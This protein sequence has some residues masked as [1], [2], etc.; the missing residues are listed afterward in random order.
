M[1]WPTGYNTAT[2]NFNSTNKPDEQK[3]GY[4]T[5]FKGE[6]R[7]TSE[8]TASQLAKLNAMFG[9]D[10]RKQP[11]WAAPNLYYVDLELNDDFTGIRWNG[12]EKTYDLDK[13]VNVVLT[14]MRKQ[15]PDFGLTGMLVA[16]GEELEDRWML[17][18]GDDG[19]AH[20]DKLAVSGHV[21]TCPHCS[22]RFVLEEQVQDGPGE[23]ARAV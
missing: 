4:S 21:V 16:Q 10:C 6:L 3:M 19:W 12:A 9:A 5:E 14:Q 8:A 15:W 7:F 17:R 22:G 13:L 1:A 18:M 2:Q 20:K 11:T 23:P